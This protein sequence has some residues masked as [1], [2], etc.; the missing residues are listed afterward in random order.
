MASSHKRFESMVRALSGDLYRYAYWL[1]RNEITAED[2]VQETFMRAWRAR[3]QLRDEN[4]AKSWLF[5]T[6]RREHA[7]LYERRRLETVDIECDD[8][9]AAG[10]DS[11]DVLALRSA[12]DSLPRKY[13]DVIALQ[14]LGG[15]TGAE[16]ADMLDVPRATVNTRLFR[17]RKRLAAAL[18]AQSPRRRADP[19]EVT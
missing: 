9:P 1:S 12:L 2:L 6:V 13:R 5:T 4:K 19:G 8:L 17:A 10:T 15:Y 16:L 7:R 14:V 18:E 3:D 11:P